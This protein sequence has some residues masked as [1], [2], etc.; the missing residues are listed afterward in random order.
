MSHLKL[1]PVELDEE[2]KTEYLNQFVE[3]SGEREELEKK[4]SETA[5][6]FTRAIKSKDESMKIL[7]Q[8]IVEGSEEQE[9]EC[10]YRKVRERGVMQEIRLDTKQVISERDLEPDEM[11]E[12]MFDGIAESNGNPDVVLPESELDP[13]EP[14]PGEIDPESYQS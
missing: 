11:N 7:R 4:R 12:N 2:K 8:A 14:T 13:D 1:L 3:L 10:D 9:V 5:K 6:E